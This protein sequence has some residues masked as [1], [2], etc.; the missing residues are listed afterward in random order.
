MYPLY[1][2]GEEDRFGPMRFVIKN[3]V[4]NIPRSNVYSRECITTTGLVLKHIE[5]ED[6]K[7]RKYIAEP[8]YTNSVFSK[9]EA[10]IIIKKYIWNTFFELSDN[11]RYCNERH[12]PMAFKIYLKDKLNIKT[13]NSHTDVDIF[14][15]LIKNKIF[16]KVTYV[17][18]PCLLAAT[19]TTTNSGD[20]IKIHNPYVYSL[21]HE[22][23][24]W[25]S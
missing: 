8:F 6:K 20:I 18:S 21:Q 11:Y 3:F 15:D 19:Y 13:L 10:E 5:T 16:K 23:K 17:F 25:L 1:N 2:I 7:S 24:H 12:Y 14:I 22:W 9:E 4:R